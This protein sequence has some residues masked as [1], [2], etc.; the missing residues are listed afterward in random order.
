VERQAL[1]HLA[2]PVED[3]PLDLALVVTPR[4]AETLER[5]LT[6]CLKRD[7]LAAELG[8]SARA[9]YRPGVRA[10]FSGPPGTGKSL[11]AAWLASKLKLPLFRVDL[12][13]VVS[14]YIGETEKN[15]ARLF[16]QAEQSEVVLL[17]DEADALFSRRTGVHDSHD[18][19][20]N[21]QTNYLLER[22][23]SFGGI[24]ILTTNHDSNLDTAFQRRLD[25]SVEFA[26]PGPQE[27]RDLWLSHL[28]EGHTLDASEINRLAAMIDWS[29]GHIRNAVLHAAASAE[30]NL[31]WQ[32]VLAGVR[33]E[34]RKLRATLPLE[35]LD[36]A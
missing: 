36:S 10:L 4:L 33:L 29:G 35:L 8:P 15:L 11:A 13:T 14:K 1:G 7:Q 32:D 26:N 31:G 27:R 20:A 18:R 28:G 9:R 22:M 12:A 21:T 24:A 19:F 16:D 25:F 17:F 2:L 34:A 30:G 3:Q 5:F 23:E 6:R